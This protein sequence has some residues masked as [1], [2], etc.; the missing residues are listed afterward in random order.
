MRTAKLQKNRAKNKYATF[1]PLF[2]QAMDYRNTGE[3]GKAIKI[4]QRLTE[5][6]PTRY[7]PPL[8]LAYTLLG[9]GEYALA[10]KYFAVAGGRGSTRAEAWL[11]G[12]TIAGTRRATLQQI[13]Q[14]CSFG[15]FSNA[16]T[17]KLRNPTLVRLE[18]YLLRAMQTLPPLTG[19]PDRHLIH[20][21]WLAYQNSPPYSAAHLL[22]PSD[23]GEIRGDDLTDYSW[24]ELLGMYLTP[25][26]IETFDNAHILD[27]CLDWIRQ[28][29]PFGL[30]EC[31]YEPDAPP[32]E[33][34]YQA[35]DCP[36][37]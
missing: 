10:A 21:Y 4:L 7:H 23:L 11:E 28:F 35:D 13:A 16:F 30:N 15:E 26:S 2:R 8:A 37:G 18:W 1:E 19:S 24:R 17:E 32:K 27:A 12:E 34:V 22:Y 6:Q 33:E 3:T 36:F 29:A 31:R 20:C 9:I 5:S 14:Q 25:E